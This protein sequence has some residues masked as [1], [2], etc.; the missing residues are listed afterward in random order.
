M[1]EWLSDEHELL[2]LNLLQEDLHESNRYDTFIEDTAFILLLTGTYNDQ[3]Q[4]PIDKQYQWLRNRGTS[5][6]E[7]HMKSLATIVNQNGNHWSLTLKTRIYPM[8][9]QC[10]DQ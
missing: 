4:Y 7:G 9:I 1:K 5:L 2:L 8:A 6:A 3:Q 10:M